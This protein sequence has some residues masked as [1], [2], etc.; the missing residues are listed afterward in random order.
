[1]IEHVYTLLERCPACGAYDALGLTGVTDHPADSVRRL[2]VAHVV[3]DA[4]A[5]GCGAL[6]VLT[7]QNTTAAAATR[8]MGIL[9]NLVRGEHARS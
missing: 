8:R 3:G 5:L 6:E 9:R 4:Y 7:V 2:S 1:M